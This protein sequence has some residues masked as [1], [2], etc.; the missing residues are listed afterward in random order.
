[1]R[2]PKLP[3]DTDKHYFY[4]VPVYDHHKDVKVIDHCEECGHKTGSHTEKRGVKIVRWEVSRGDKDLLW[5]SNKLM[6]KRMADN[7]FEGNSIVNKLLG[8][9]S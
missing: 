7:M 5:H 2:K 9:K 3:P 6:M 4:L 8:K 1:M